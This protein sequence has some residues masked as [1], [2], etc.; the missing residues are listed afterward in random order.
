MNKEPLILAVIPARGGSK[1]I[2]HKNIKLL[3]GKPLLAYSIEVA[4]QCKMISDI[5]V[6]TDDELIK[7]I[8]L[9]YGAE[10]PF[11]R[12]AELSTD[13][14]LA[15]PAIQHAVHQAEKIKNKHY[16]Y[17]IMLQPTAPLR[18]AEDVTNALRQLIDSYAD[19]I[20]S[21]V[22]VDNWHPMKMKKFVDGWLKDYEKPP[23]E[24]PPRQVLPKVYMVNGAIYATRR[25]FLIDF[26]TFQG[27]RCLGYIMPAERS[28]NIDSEIDFEIAELMIQKMREE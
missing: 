3:A 16:D 21:V 18:A 6:S 23:M 22:D 25:D 13:T 12:P 7:G 2:P 5:V 1:G 11:L 24:N 27:N 28:I 19:G 4:L 8:A 20:I 15:I 14:A 10:V 9:R 17:I 26:S